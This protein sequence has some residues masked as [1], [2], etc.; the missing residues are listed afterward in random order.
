MPT[1]LPSDEPLRDPHDYVVEY[2]SAETLSITSDSTTTTEAASSDNEAN[3]ADDWALS[4]DVVWTP[5]STVGRILNKAFND[6]PGVFNRLPSSAQ[7]HVREAVW[8][9]SLYSYVV[10][11]H[12]CLAATEL[13]LLSHLCVSFSLFPS[14]L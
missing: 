3:D 11:L 1:I 7:A 12:R 8:E 14:P 6:T 13:A 2:Q 5:L 9:L 4:N 10:L